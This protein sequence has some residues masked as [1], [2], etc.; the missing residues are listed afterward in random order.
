MR[1]LA[2]IQDASM[3]AL[4]SKNTFPTLARHEA[5][6]GRNDY[7]RLGVLR[8]KPGRADSPPALSMS[9]SDKMA[10]WNVLGIQ[11]SFGS[12]FLEPVYLN[13]IILGEVP[14][15]EELRKIVR[16]DCE[17]ALKERITGVKGLY[18]SGSGYEVSC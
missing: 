5:S 7:N 16:E 1:Y 2:S 12:R 11:G 4:K 17:R 10:R 8:T 3:A 9:C 18:S 6:R 15:E 14:T 13:G